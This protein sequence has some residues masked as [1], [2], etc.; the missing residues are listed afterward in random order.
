[1]HV[2]HAAAARSNDLSTNNNPSQQVPGF[3][4]VPSHHHLP[5][6]PL[7]PPVTVMPNP[8]SCQIRHSYDEPAVRSQLSS[9]CPPLSNSLI[10][11]RMSPAPCHCSPW[12]SRAAAASSLFLLRPPSASVLVAQRVLMPACLHLFVSLH[13][14]LRACNRMCP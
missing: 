7:Q 2:H 13:V 1:M 5:S 14:P 4:D 8:V 12:R 10:S 3:L 11:F 9:R 6:P